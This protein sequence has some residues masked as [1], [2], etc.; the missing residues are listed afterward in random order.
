MPKLAYDPDGLHF[1]EMFAQEGAVE[2]VP[3]RMSRVDGP[4]DW[5]ETLMT[6]KKETN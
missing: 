4:D 1:A 5:D 2:L 6:D 3:G